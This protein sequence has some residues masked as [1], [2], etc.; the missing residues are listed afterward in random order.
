[1]QS[2]LNFTTDKCQPLKRWPVYFVSAVLGIIPLFVI[3]KPL[4]F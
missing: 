4:M 1:M 3:F 2:V